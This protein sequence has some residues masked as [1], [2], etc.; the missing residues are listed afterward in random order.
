M[1]FLL[2]VVV[3][4]CSSTNAQ[5]VPGT[6]VATLTVVFGQ[7]NASP[8]PALAPYYC[9][10]WATDTSPAYTPNSVV[11]VYGKYTHT[12]DGNPVGVSG[13]SAAATVLWPDGSS[14]TENTTTGSDGL[15]VFAITMQA[16]AINHVVLIQMK[17]TIPNVPSC[18][19]TSPA[20]FTAI[21]VSPTPTNTAMPSPTNTG[22]PGATPSV[23]P[24]AGGTI[25]PTGTPKIT[26]TGKPGG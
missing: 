7:S 26:P 18:T 12:V 10:G 20:F 8:T 3:V 2:T 1:L 21:L 13:A 23:S 24:T 9:G 11:S 14:V 25:T 6:P 4:A 17:F 22:S 15:A 5:I 16:S 19:L